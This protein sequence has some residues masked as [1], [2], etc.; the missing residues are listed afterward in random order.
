MELGIREP[1]TPTIY[2][3]NIGA[4]YLSANPLFHFRMK[5]IALDYHFVRC[6]IQSGQ[7][8]VAHVHTSDQLADA[9]TKPLDRPRFD[10][11]TVKIG[12]TSGPSVLR[13][14]DKI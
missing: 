4:N 7:M 12:L 9:L 13:G 3:D 10:T 1:A 11:L 8:R 6:Y 2:C 5:H 14:R